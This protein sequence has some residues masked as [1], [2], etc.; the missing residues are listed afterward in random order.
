VH[1]QLLLKL[2]LEADKF[3]SS[4]TVNGSCST[5]IVS[6]W[7]NRI[8][9]QPFICAKN[10]MVWC[11]QERRYY[12]SGLT[13]LPDF[14]RDQS[15]TV[16]HR[17]GPRNLDSALSEILPGFQ[18]CRSSISICVKVHEH[19]SEDRER[20]VVHAASRQ[21]YRRCIPPTR[22]R[23]TIFASLEGR[24][25]TTLPLGASLSSHK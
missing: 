2:L 20:K 14:C 21:A 13:V 11:C 16:V 7:T 24:A 15:C 17:N 25:V 19:E 3:L 1:G 10:F 23:T 5:W 22:G 9:N 4:G 8:A 18:A 6:W 12:Q